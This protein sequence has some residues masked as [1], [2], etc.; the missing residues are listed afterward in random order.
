MADTSYFM[1]GMSLHLF[2][3]AGTQLVQIDYPKIAIMGI[4]MILSGPLLGAWIT[5]DVGEQGAIWC[6]FSVLL[7]AVPAITGLIGK[8]EPLPAYLG[9]KET[10]KDL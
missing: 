4:F 8:P 6:F 10:K 7:V 3:L 5:P 1:P 2:L 9:G